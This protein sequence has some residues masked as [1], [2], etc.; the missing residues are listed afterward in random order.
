MMDK[1][2]F[3][4]SHGKVTVLKNNESLHKNYYSLFDLL[5]DVNE[6]S[7]FIGEATF[8]SFFRDSRRNEFILRCEAEGHII[9]TTPNRATGRM[10]EKLGLEKTDEN[11]VQAIRAI[12]NSG[13]HLKVPRV[14]DASDPFLSVRA[15]A[16]KELMILRA[17]KV[18]IPKKNGVGFLKAT[19]SEKD[20]FAEDLIARLPDINSIP[21][22]I[23]KY[24][25]GTEYNKVIVAAVGVCGKFVNSQRGFDKL[26]GL[27]HHGYPSQIRSDLH[28]WGWSRRLRG[29]PG[30][31]L[32]GYRRALR[33]LFRQ[34]KAVM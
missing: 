2:Y 22:D 6:P 16:N 33:W 30:Y 8:E 15:A 24:L 29:K 5:D 20:L 9:L 25:G 26:S 10:R 1:Y 23:S 27:Y 32:S 12:A 28:L 11:D 7:I 13:T 3:D 14:F 31:S 19:K 18:R 17:S 21:E 4:W 34:I